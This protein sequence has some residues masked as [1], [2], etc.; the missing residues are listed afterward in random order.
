MLGFTD[1]AY[2]RAVWAVSPCYFLAVPIFEDAGFSVANGRLR[3]VPEEKG[4]DGEVGEGVDLEAL[5]RG[6]REVDESKE[7]PNKPVSY[8]LGMMMGGVG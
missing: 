7:W 2:T 6:L 8:S 4:Q 5:E 1:P 3:D